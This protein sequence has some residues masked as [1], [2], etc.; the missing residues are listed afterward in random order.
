MPEAAHCLES[1]Y[2][3]ET[4]YS[5]KRDK[6]WVGYKVHL[7][8]SCDEGLPH[9]ITGVYTIPATATDVKQLPLIQE[10]LQQSGVDPAQ[11]LA[12]AA[13]LCGGNL[14]CSESHR[15]DLIGPI[16]QDHTWQAKAGEGFDVA[17]FQVDWGNK[18]VTCPKGRESVRWSQTTTAR[19]KSMIDV[20]FAST[21]CAPCPSRSLCTR[22]K[23]QPRNLTL[24]PQQEHEAIQ[25]ARRRQRTQEF[26]EIYSQRAGIERTVSQGVRAFGLRQ[27]RYREQKKTHLQ[28]LATAAA[29]N[30]CRVADWLNEVPTATT[31]RSRLAALAPAN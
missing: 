7:T 21:D 23:N 29:V 31:R 12:D 14:V 11:Q 18:K 26:A 30:V 2:E 15:I 24:Q 20:G 3:S 17:N 8:E 6:H 1:P 28:Q 5:N 16:Y 19:G 25:S 22:A 9:L 4:R 13:Y 10:S 27:A